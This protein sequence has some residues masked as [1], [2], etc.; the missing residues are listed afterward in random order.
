MPQRWSLLA[1]LLLAVAP[2]RVAHAN[3]ARS[4]WSGELHGPLMA[5]GPTQVRVDSEELSFTVA[6]DLATAQVVATYHL[7]NGGAA[8]SSGDVAFVFERGE[9]ERGEGEPQAAPPSVTI[10]GIAAAFRA[11]TEPDEQASRGS[12]WT[13]RGEGTAPLGWFVFSLEFAPGQK[14]TVEVRYS[15]SSSRDLEKHVNPT[16]TY[17]YL[18]SPAKSWASFG[19][20][21]LR[22]QLPAQ[23]QL[24]SSTIPL[25]REGASDHAEL[26]GLP[27]GELTFAV[28]SARGLWFGRNSRASYLRLVALVL[29]L[30][31]LPLAWLLG[32]GW[33]RSRPTMTTAWM[34]LGIGALVLVLSIAVVVAAGAVM[35]QHAFGFGFGEFAVLLFC[36]VIAVLVGM[37]VAGF[38]AARRRPDRSHTQSG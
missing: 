38:A 30:V 22:V 25:R 24:L 34:V 11:V 13:R 5:Q 23:T 9:Q 27:E 8:A 29:A 19:A 33:R 1:L 28:S 4:Y 15:H 6:D 35:P 10:D 7:T 37:I 31:A 17:H 14:R 32:R 16:F 26:T 18:L 2:S 12:A 3:M 20:L 36:I 21:R